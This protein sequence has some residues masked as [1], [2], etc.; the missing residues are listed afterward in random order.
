MP[1]VEIQKVA[2]TKKERVDLKVGSFFYSDFLVHQQLHSDVVIIVNGRELQEDDELDFEITPTHFIQVFD[3]PKGV[4]GDILNPVFN[5]VTKVFSFLAPKTPSFSA[6]ESNVKDSPNNRL[7]GQTN[8]ARAYQ[9]RPEIHG[10]VRAFPDLIQQSMFEYNNNLKTVT[11]WLNIGI[12]EYKTESIRFAESDFTAMAGA[13][14]KIYKPK[15]VI[16]LINEGFEFPDIDGQEL[17]GPNES[18]DIPQQTATANEVVSGEIKGGEAAIKIVKQDEF[19]YFYELTKPRSISMTVNVSYDTPQGSVTKDVKIDAQLVDAKESDDGS[20]INPVEYYEFFFTNLTGTDLAQLPPNAVVNTTKFILYDNQFLTVGPF[21]SPVDGDQ[22]W[23]HLQA[24]LGGGDNCNATVEIWKINTDNEEIAGTRQ[25]FNTA[26]SAN[27]GARVYYKTDK[28]T[29]NSGRGRYAV[30]L[31]RRNNSSDQSIMKIE[32]AHI[33]RVRDNVVFENDTIVNVSV[34]ATEAP[35][36]ARERKYNLL[37]TRMHISYDRVSKQ[38][39]YTL[40]PSRSFADAVLHTW[41]ITAGESEKNIDIDGLYRI[42]DSLPDERLGYFDYTFDDE[43]ISLGQRI[44]TICNAARVTAYFDNAVLTFSREQSSEFPMTTFNRSNI[45]GNDMKISYDMSMPSGYDG[46]ELEYVEP[47]RNKKD[48]I[49]FRVNENGITEGLSRT[50]NKIVLQGCRNRYQAMDRALL[51]ANR[52]IHQRTSISLTTLADGG[53][54]YPSDMVLIADTYDSNQQAGYI[55][56][57]KGEVFTTS[58]KIKFDEEMWVYL[59]DSMGYTTQKFKAEP[60]P[61]TEFGFIA[62]VPEDIELNFYDGYQ[63]QSSSRYVIATSVELEN[64][65]WVITDK[66]PL[67]GERY[68]ITAT[69]Y[70]DAKPDYNA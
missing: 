12:G 14:Y 27:N 48:Y 29:L 54:V 40:R 66:R 63:K 38:V 55:T 64:I 26:L 20:L 15:E 17:P 68:T 36:G 1:I 52:L 35:T 43:D 11:E 61:D 56:E 2:G 25:S 69:E 21:F 3:Q 32:N 37:A 19:E 59:T 33:V 58:E 42:Y 45:T 70:F 4:I 5:L 49:R 6:A 18:K 16:P 67:G 34:R 8:V 10:Q 22:M 53:N 13:S 57:R 60:R 46:I 9:A 47:V 41:L 50:P 62:S 30:Q 65:K 24:Q 28:V 44:E 7:T 51:E 39:D 23:I 31:T